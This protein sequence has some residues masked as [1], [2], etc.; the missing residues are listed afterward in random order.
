MIFR[1]IGV[2]FARLVAC[3][4]HP[5]VKSS[6]HEYAFASKG[7]EKW[8]L[9]A[10]MKGDTPWRA[11]EGVDV[12]RQRLVRRYR[13]TTCLIERAEEER[14]YIVEDVYSSAMW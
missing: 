2:A 9:D 1:R 11:E 12:E 8:S 7:S 10:V 3:V 14:H 4:Q 6:P 5:A 13:R